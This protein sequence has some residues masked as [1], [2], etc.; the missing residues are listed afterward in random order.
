MAALSASGRSE[1]AI[2]SK[3]GEPHVSLKPQ[4]EPLRH[5]VGLCSADSAVTGGTTGQLRAALAG[6]SPGP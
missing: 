4:P 3:A 5:P 1:A 2:R 6:D